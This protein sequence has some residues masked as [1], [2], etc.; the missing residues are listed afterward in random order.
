[1]SLPINIQNLFKEVWEKDQ[2][3]PG[4]DITPTDFGHPDLEWEY[5]SGHNWATIDDVPVFFD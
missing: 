1:M 3:T 2:D 4:E 5:Q